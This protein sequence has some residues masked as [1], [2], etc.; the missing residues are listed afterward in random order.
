MKIAYRI[1]TIALLLVVLRATGQ[2]KYPLLSDLDDTL[3]SVAESI[4]RGR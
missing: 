4:F 3:F 2:E 1:V